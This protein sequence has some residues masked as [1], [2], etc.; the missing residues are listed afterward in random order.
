MKRM[1]QKEWLTSPRNC[2]PVCR[3]TDIDSTGAF[4]AHEYEMFCSFC[5]QTYVEVMK[6]VGYRIV[7]K[8]SRSPEANECREAFDAVKNYAEDYAERH[9]ENND[10]IVIGRDPHK[11]SFSD[12]TEE[13]LENFGNPV[14]GWLAG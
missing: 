1:K 14:Q 12:M 3:S 10:P 8:E 7:K 9:G 2:C 11:K 13:E 5:G 4:D 6:L